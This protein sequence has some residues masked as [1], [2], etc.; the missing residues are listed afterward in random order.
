M[1]L[2]QSA[3]INILFHMELLKLFLI[4]LKIIRENGRAKDNIFK[5]TAEKPAVRLD[6]SYKHNCFGE[7]EG[8]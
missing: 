3:S 4:I 8:S 7:S 2:R 1:S 6:K 5:I